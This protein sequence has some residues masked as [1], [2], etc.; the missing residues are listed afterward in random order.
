[1]S[2]VHLLADVARLGIKLEVCGDRLRYHPRSLV[3]SDLVARLK[4]R[5]AE[6]LPLLG[7]G[8]PATVIDPCGAGWHP[9]WLDLEWIE[10]VG[11][12]G[13]RSLIHPDHGDDQWEEI[14]GLEPCHQCGRYELWRT[15]AGTWRCLRCD[16]PTT[17]RWVM[18]EAARIQ[19]RELRN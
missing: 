19:E 12:D 4:A 2:L 18:E 16:P 17:A 13:R 10:R 1:M 6:L 11:P 9:G 7:G 5:K 14:D 15:L 8:D 3:T